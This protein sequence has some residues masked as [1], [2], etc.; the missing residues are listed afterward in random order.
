MPTDSQENVTNRIARTSL[1]SIP[2]LDMVKLFKLNGL[3]E[4][5]VKVIVSDNPRKDSK[6]FI[7]VNIG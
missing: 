4:N 5:L 1:L 7:Q 3:M 2:G 6:H